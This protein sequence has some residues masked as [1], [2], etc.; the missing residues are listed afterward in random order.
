MGLAYPFTHHPCWSC[1]REGLWARIHLPVAPSCNVK[2]A[3]CDHQLDA[4]GH[5]PVPGRSR[6]VMTPTQA[7]KVTLDELGKDPN[8]R[9]VAV[10]GPGEPLACPQTFKTLRGIR[11]LNADID[12]CL[13]TNG[14]LLEEKTKQLVEL[15]ARTISVTMS[16]V[17]PETASQ[18]YEWA[19]IDGKRLIGPEMG[20][21]VIDAQ[22]RGISSATK[23]GVFVKVNSI[24]IP[25][26]N[27]EQMEALARALKDAGA[28]L[29]NIV[30]LIPFDNMANERPPTQNELQ[31][32]RSIASRFMEQF[33]HCKQ[34]RSDVVGIPGADR[35]L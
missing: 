14:V 1:N 11:A 16:T 35:I 26:M 2:C 8:L 25:E 21:K 13:S 9:I 23:S 19:M 34:C 10:S 4:S 15:G 5:M 6:R 17:S 28:R 20:E 7:V 12:F 33:Y 32:A 29:Q 22:L 24:L 27:G 18:I 31:D 30:P 3:Y